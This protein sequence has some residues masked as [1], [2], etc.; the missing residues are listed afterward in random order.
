MN[1]ALKAEGTSYSQKVKN[2]ISSYGKM[3]P[4]FHRVVQ[5][6]RLNAYWERGAWR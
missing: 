6:V 1:T 5:L 4:S 3:F 2:R